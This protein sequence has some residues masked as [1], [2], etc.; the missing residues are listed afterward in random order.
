M[1][2]YV[3][4]DSTAPWIE[5]PDRGAFILCRTSNPGAADLQDVQATTDSEVRPL[6]EV[7]AERARSWDRHGNVGLVV[8]A[9]YPGEMRR[10]RELCPDLPFLVP[11]VGAQHGALKESIRAGI[12]ARGAGM[13]ISASR[14]VTYASR[15]AD[16]A[17]AARAA[18]VGV[19]DA[20]E[21]E[22]RAIASR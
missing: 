2:P 18:A 3:G 13:L 8:G 10:L 15:G 5:R 14:G 19:R 22:R 6:Y 17:D 11:G 16:Y 7:V 1:N 12:D 4:Y 21:A 20:I 9:T